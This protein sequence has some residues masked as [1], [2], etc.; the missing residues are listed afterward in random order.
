MVGIYS[1]KNSK[2]NK[3]YIGSSVDIK[4]RWRLHKHELLNNKH[5]SQY[6][7][8]SWNKY[9][10]DV[11][12]FEI[13]EECDTLFLLEREQFYIDTFNPE[14]NSN[15]VAGNCTSRIL[16]QES[17]D[18]ISKGNLGKI[19]SE[20]TK[21]LMSLYRINN[22]LVFTDEIRT[23]I[24]KSKL[25]SNNPMYGKT[26]TEKH[27]KSISESN[28]GKTHNNLSKK[29]IGKANSIAIIQLDMDGN[30]IK[31]WSSTMEVQRELEGFLGNGITRV[32]K[33]T[34][35]QYKGYIWIYKTE[36]YANN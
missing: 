27:R 22:P 14:Y 32:C 23:K 2:N 9:G 3:I 33:K 1:I 19:H 16:S 18:K 11:F 6:L 35:K 26:F 15:V 25:G 30:F 4:S 17:K 28:K 24:S 8:R 20:E 21:K 7:Q 5:H 31:E 10:E 29:L 36:Y 13:M 34:R 12:I